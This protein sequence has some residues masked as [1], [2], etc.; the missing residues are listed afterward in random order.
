MPKNFLQRCNQRYSFTT[1]PMLRLCVLCKSIKKA[2]NAFVLA[3]H[4][5]ARHLFSQA[6]CRSNHSGTTNWSTCPQCHQ[7]LHSCVNNVQLHKVINRSV[8][9]WGNVWILVFGLSSIQSSSQTLVFSEQNRHQEWTNPFCS[10]SSFLRELVNSH[11]FISV[12]C[13]ESANHCS[14]CGRADWSKP[15]CPW[16]ELWMQSGAPKPFLPWPGG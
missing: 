6:M 9:Y 12:G 15:F 13:C 8:N 14:V 2:Q 1:I 7:S 16:F 3:G 11:V 5:F 4:E 10:T